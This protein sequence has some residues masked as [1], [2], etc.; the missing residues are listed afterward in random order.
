MNTT[1]TDERAEDALRQKFLERLD[2]A[3]FE[4]G[5]WEAQFIESFLEAPRPFS[6]GQRQAVDQMRESYE[7]RL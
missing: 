3:P 5:N 2:A 7:G 1:F 4:V 6:P